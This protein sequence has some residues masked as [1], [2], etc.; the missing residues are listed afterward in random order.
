MGAIRIYRVD[1]TTLPD[2]EMDRLL[3]LFDELD[4]ERV[5]EDPLPPWSVRA[6]RLRNLPPIAVR[7]SWVARGDAEVVGYGSVVRWV[8]GENDH[9][10]EA[11]IRVRPTWRRRGVARALLARIAEA[12]A[13]V[14]DATLFLG[15]SDRVPAGEAF[16]R[17]I[18]AEQGIET[19]VNQLDLAAVDRALVDT[20]C[21]LGETTAADYWLEWIPSPVPD[22]RVDA[23]LRAFELMNTAPRGRLAMNDWR[24]TADLLR[25]FE[26]RER[27]LGLES[28]TL[29]GFHRESGAVAG[30][31]Q[32]NYDPRLSHVVQQEGTA[33]D[34]AHRGHGL[35]KLLKATMLRRVLV[36]RSR[37]RYIRTGNADSN[38]PMLSLNRRLG[39]RPAWARI[40]WQATLPI[41]ASYLERAGER[42]AEPAT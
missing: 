13:K 1:L 10:A 5:P 37:A 17:R 8:T 26:A 23:V 32:V 22:E 39:F 36:E 2:D 7:K 42:V 14:K 4:Q 28:W 12:I 20:W 11:D 18:G 9:I 6:A 31:T 19:H 38:A 27:A 3:A 41:V 25:Q 21:A 30:F 40:V 29:F 24:M 35:G 33:V 34:P 15:T 16:V